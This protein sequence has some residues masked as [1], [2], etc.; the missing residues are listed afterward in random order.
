MEKLPIQIHLDDSFFLE[1]EKCGYKITAQSKKLW[2]VLLDLMV[3]F[4]A[5]CREH[6]IRYT[7]DSGTL[8]GAVRHGGFIPWDNDID[9]AMLRSEYEKLCKIAPKTFKE[10]YFWQTNQTDSG[11]M[12]RHAQLRNSLT[13]D[14]LR[15]EMEHDNPL[16]V[17]NQGV[18]LDVFVLDEVP[19][20]PD[21]LQW[22]RDE[23]QQYVD[24][25][26][27]FKD[28]Y[29]LGNKIPFWLEFA[30][31]QAY[32]EF[33][34]T[35]A[36]YNGSGMKRVGHISLM[37]YRKESALIPKE[38]YEDFVNYNFEGYTFLG[39]KDYDT[40]LAGFYGN[41][42]EMVIGGDAHGEVFLDLYHPYTY[43][44]RN[45]KAPHVQKKHPLLI[46]LKFKK[47]LLKHSLLAIKNLLYT[48]NVFANKRFR[49]C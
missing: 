33:E 13:T 45:A 7:I 9:V 31:K 41:W 29:R 38:T 10:P 2:A 37:P 34:R 16:Y 28:S 43:Y 23:L 17:F 8:L 5:V 1:E 22:F 42:H 36:R 14:I 3:Q 35:V 26:W 18:F 24:V 21:E 20:N 48:I 25:L 40:I 44:L 12:R 4:D 19:D 6:N 47:L 32:D 15:S 49:I 30:Q 46:L 27:E 11:S 39:V